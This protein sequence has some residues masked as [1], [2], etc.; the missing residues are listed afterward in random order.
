M[1][2][3]KTI[4][5]KFC[6]KKTERGDISII[7]CDTC[8]GYCKYYIQFEKSSNSHVSI[9][10]SNNFFCVFQIHF[11]PCFAVLHYLKQIRHIEH[12]VKMYKVSN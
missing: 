10:D 2:K 6:N 12:S 4:T 9:L 1:P 5:C 3:T 8:K 7:Q 11:L